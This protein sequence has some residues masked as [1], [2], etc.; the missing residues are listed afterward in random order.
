VQVDGNL[1]LNNENA[2][3]Q[4][5]LAGLGVALLPTYIVGADLQRGD[6]CSAL[7]QYDASET[8]L[9][10]VYLP[11]RELSPKVRALVDFLLARFGPAPYWDDAA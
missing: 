9:Y 6:L 4:A 11:N 5:A 1:R 8:A 10:A 2:I 3:R 7:S